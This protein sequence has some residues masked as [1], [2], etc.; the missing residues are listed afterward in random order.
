MSREARPPSALDDE[1]D[2]VDPPEMYSSPPMA[3]ASIALTR[4]PTS[5]FTLGS[6]CSGGRNRNF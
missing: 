2:A 5:S 6:T 1:E 4:G 3:S